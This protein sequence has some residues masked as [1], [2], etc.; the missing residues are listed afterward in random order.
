[1]RLKFYP[2]ITLMVVF[3]IAGTQALHSQEL[4][5]TLGRNIREVENKY[6]GQATVEFVGGGIAL[7][8]G[9]VV[10]SI[11]FAKSNSE[12]E[13]GCQGGGECWDGFGEALAG[14]GVLAL[15]I[16]IGGGM[17]LAGSGDYYRG[18]QFKRLRLRYEAG[19]ITAPEAEL[20]FS[21]LAANAQKARYITAAVEGGVAALILATSMRQG[22]MASGFVGASPFLALAAWNM[23][24][25]SHAQDGWNKHQSES[26]SGW[27]KLSFYVTPQ[28]H[29]G[30]SAG[31]T[32]SF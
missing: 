7:G 30:L 12:Q 22:N 17:I 18:N 13:R 19:E 28:P 16:G 24:T 2:F 11:L 25:D 9:I 6:K 31:V 4:S 8:T 27:N 32:F 10:S 23:I 1:M 29:S 14:A 26:S 15:G 5:Q 20:E 3:C 21:E